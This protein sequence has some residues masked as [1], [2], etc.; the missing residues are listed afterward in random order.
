M[1]INMKIFANN[2]FEHLVSDFVDASFNCLTQALFEICN[3]FYLKNVLFNLQ[4]FVSENFV[5]K[6]F[7]QSRTSF[8]KVIT[9]FIIFANLH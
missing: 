1:K 8:R 7:L 5:V 9:K 3:F 4:T 6:V 2:W